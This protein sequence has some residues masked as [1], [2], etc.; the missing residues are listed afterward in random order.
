MA[1]APPPDTDP[2]RV[3]LG[4]L[5]LT[6]VVLV[7]LGVAILVDDPVARLV[8]AAIVVFTVG[9]TWVLRRAIRHGA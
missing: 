5:L 3:R 2:R 8:M 7:A 9:R 6:V 1:D 4:L